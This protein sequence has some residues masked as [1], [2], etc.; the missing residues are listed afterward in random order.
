[1]DVAVIKWEGVDWVKWLRTGSS[2][3]F[4]EYDDASL[5]SISPRNF[6]IS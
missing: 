2:G 6:L 1:M 5:G 3:G 4:C